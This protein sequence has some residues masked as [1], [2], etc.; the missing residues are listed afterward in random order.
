MPKRAY[1]VQSLKVG[2][3]RGCGSRR[4]VA[5]GERNQAE[6]LTSEEVSYIAARQLRIRDF[7]DRGLRFGYTRGYFTSEDRWLKTHVS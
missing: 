3:V 1:S 7:S 2:D 5:N 4:T 6:S